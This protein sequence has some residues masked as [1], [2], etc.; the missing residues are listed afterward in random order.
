LDDNEDGYRSIITNLI[1]VDCCTTT[2]SAGI[3]ISRSLASSARD[4]DLDDTGKAEKSDN[5]GK[6]KPRYHRHFTRRCRRRRRHHLHHYTISGLN[7]KHNIR[8]IE[9]YTYPDPQGSAIIDRNL[10]PSSFATVI[11]SW[12]AASIAPHPRVSSRIATGFDPFQQLRDQAQGYK[13]VAKATA[14]Q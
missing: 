5:A 2:A 14:W 6:L 4:L 7:G 13:Q 3:N 1:V 8:I 10:D 9:T 12:L 11:T